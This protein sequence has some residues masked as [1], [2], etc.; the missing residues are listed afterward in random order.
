MRG[1]EQMRIFT[2]ILLFILGIGALGGAW[3]LMTDPSGETLGI[4]L[5]LLQTTP[6]K[7]YLIPGILLFTFIGLLSLYVM[8]L[9]LKKSNKYPLYLIV[10][11]GI[12]FSWLTIELMINRNFYVHHLHIPLYLMGF[13]FIGMGFK[14]K[15]IK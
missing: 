8:A 14:L 10:Q 1:A 9:G 7:N 5:A 3:M 13:I 15:K 11:G 4:P 2:I 6:F 12:L